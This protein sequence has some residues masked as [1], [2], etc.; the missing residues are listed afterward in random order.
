MYSYV[1]IHCSQ[2]LDFKLLFPFC[3]KNPIEM[4]M[5]QFKQTRIYFVNSSV[6]FRIAEK[7]ISY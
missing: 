5:L 4:T 2:I 1:K 7:M 6:T 3:I